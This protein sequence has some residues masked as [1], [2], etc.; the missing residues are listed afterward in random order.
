MSTV[1]KARTLMSSPPPPP[2]PPPLQFYDPWTDTVNSSHLPRGDWGSS[3]GKLT[4]LVG[5]TFKSLTK[6]TFFDLTLDF[7]P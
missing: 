4:V 2:P 7:R 1:V 6:V 3:G 5:A